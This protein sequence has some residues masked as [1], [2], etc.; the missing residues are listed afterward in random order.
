MNE[1]KVFSFKKK[2]CTTLDP[3]LNGI[4]S[5]EDEDEPIGQNIFIWFQ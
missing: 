1:K 4:T 5:F 3:M 2:N